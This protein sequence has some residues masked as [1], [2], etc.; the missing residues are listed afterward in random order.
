MLLSNSAP[1]T[2]PRHY[3]YVGPLAWEPST[4]GPEFSRAPGALWVLV[5]SS[6]LPQ[7]GEA[8]IARAA[9]LEHE[10]VRV[11]G[12]LAPDHA[13][14]LGESLPQRLC[15]TYHL[16]ILNLKVIGCMRDPR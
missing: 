13:V 7:A 16:S 3:R 8:A 6:T 15:P 12:T 1:T 4:V 9:A 5:A 2:L 14:E 11:L 10:A